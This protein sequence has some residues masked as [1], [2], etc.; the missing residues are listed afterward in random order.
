M[1]AVLPA[2]SYTPVDYSGGDTTIEAVYQ[3]GDAGYVFQVSPSGSFSGTLTIMVGVSGEGQ[4]TGVEIVKTAETSGLGANAGQARVP[5]AVCGRL[6][7]RLRS[8][9]NG[10]RDR[11]PHR[12]YH[13]LTCGVRRSQFRPGRRRQSGL[14]RAEQ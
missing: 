6:W 13:Y 7:Q 10:R 3:A 9:R 4:V 1:A 14:R 8:A 2:D 11:R 12:R 5:R